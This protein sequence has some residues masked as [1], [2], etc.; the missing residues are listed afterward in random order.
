M[1]LGQIVQVI[2]T[3]G[4]VLFGG[5][6]L[7][8][9]NR[10]KNIVVL[11]SQNIPDNL[12]LARAISIN[13]AGEINAT[14]TG[15][16]VLHADAGRD[17]GLIHWHDD[18]F[19]AIDNDHAARVF[20]IAFSVSAAGVIPGAIIGELAVENASNLLEISDLIKPHDTI[21]LTGECTPNPVKAIQSVIITEA[22][23][24]I[25]G[26]TDSLELSAAAQQIRFR[27]GSADR[28][29]CAF[30]YQ[31]H[32]HICTFPC[33]SSATM[34]ATPT[35]TWDSY[36]SNSDILS[37]CK[38]TNSVYAIYGADSDASSRIRTFSINANGTINKSFL[39]TKIVDAKDL[40]TVYMTEIGGGYFITAYGVSGVPGR[41]RTFHIADDGLT[42][43]GPISS[44]DITSTGFSFPSIIHLQGDIWAFSFLD[45]AAQIMIYTLEIET[46]T[47]ARPHH[48]MI[49]KIGP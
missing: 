17:L 38:V 7:V 29:V 43:T 4:F 36:T 27:Q 11:L 47:E 48:E 2:D 37:L 33:T 9:R 31:G 40:A 12:P 15:S 6:A 32:I 13:D 3:Q 41:L 10:N 19:V 42:I 39:A 1:A 16:L 49:M 21:I 23:S 24:F 46:P 8:L 5:K 35:D 30:T 34:P 28:I 25:N 44:L 18:V 14:P 45:T 20:L 26:L 22:G